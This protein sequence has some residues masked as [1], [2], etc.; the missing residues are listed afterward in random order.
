M[1]NGTRMVAAAL[2]LA[3]LPAA[4]A[5]QNR[6]HQQIF[7]DMRIL[8]ESVAKLQLSANTLTEQ[9]QAINKRIDAQSADAVKAFAEQRLVINSLAATVSTVREKLEDN[10]VRVSQMTTEM[11]AIREGLRLLTDQLNQLLGLL[12]PSTMPG[13]S[14]SDPPGG[15]GAGTGAG[16]PPPGGINTVRMPNSP[17]DLYNAALADY[18]SGLY[19]LAIGGFKDFVEKFPKRPMRRGRCST[20]VSRTSP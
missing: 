20:S 12:Q 6:E 16:A 1:M 15:V 13:A 11:G 10:T 4:A 14:P 8:Q 7:A 9:I 3:L 17:R 19:D 18:M 5:A 2:T